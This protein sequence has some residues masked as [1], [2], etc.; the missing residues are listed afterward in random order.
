MEGK[1]GGDAFFDA[2]A[3]LPTK[4]D[5]AIALLWFSER[6]RQTEYTSVGTLSDLFVFAR[7]PAPNTTR[8]RRDLER[9][10][11]VLKNTKGFR[12][13]R[14]DFSRE[15]AKFEVLFASAPRFE[16]RFDIARTPFLSPEEVAEARGMASLYVVAHCL[17]NSI[18]KLVSAVLRKKLGDSWWAVAASSAMKRKQQ[19]R[20]ANEKKR[21]WAPTRSDLG[22]L[23]AVDWQD[24]CTL[25][26]KYESDF[27]PFIGEVNFLH[28]FDDLGS[29]RNIIAH[30]GYFADEKNITRVE[31]S[32]QDWV[33]Q[34]SEKAV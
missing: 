23:Y 4:I 24:L 8:M 2:I 26:R 9:D 30:N 1:L 7:L 20:I 5:Q 13:R 32:W 17:E 3:A 22:P 12:L 11:R 25:M 28:R 31:L 33:S 27:L 34:L 10:R 6:E 15:N 14:E 18:R 29:L 19:D 21:R 16:E